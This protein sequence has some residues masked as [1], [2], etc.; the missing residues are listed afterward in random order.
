MNTPVYTS[1]AEGFRP[2]EEIAALR[3]IPEPK[4]RRKR[5]TELRQVTNGI[6]C[7]CGERFGESDALDFM[8]HM[9]A[10]VGED[11]A[12]LETSE[13]ASN[14]AAR[15][16]YSTDPEYRERQ[17]A[18]STARARERYASSDP[19]ERTRYTAPREC[20]RPRA[21]RN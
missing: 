18:R 6:V 3:P 16:R 8:L 17:R 14:A 10:E 11:L 20:A 4:P 5:K 2:A 7:F 9:R 15:R 13:S 19:E 21:A 1:K 12:V